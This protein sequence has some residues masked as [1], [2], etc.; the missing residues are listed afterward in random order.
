M[1]NIVIPLK[2]YILVAFWFVPCSFGACRCYQPFRPSDLWLFPSEYLWLFPS[3]FLWLLPRDFSWLYFSYFYNVIFQWIMTL[4]RCDLWL[5]L[6]VTSLDFI[7][8]LLHMTLFP[9]WWLFLWEFLWRQLL[10]TS[11]YYYYLMLWS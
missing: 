5:Y 9:Q 3:D 8:K 2:M 4:F 7:C 6:Q 11:Y 1:N 10:V